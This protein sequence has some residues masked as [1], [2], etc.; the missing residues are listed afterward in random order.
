M[1]L[2]LLPVWV[3]QRRT[4]LRIACCFVFII[5]EHISILYVIVIY[6]NG[7]KKKRSFKIKWVY[8]HFLWWIRRFTIYKFVIEFRLYRTQRYIKSLTKVDFFPHICVK[9][10]KTICILKWVLFSTFYCFYLLEHLHTTN[11]KNRN[12]N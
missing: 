7:K 8:R 9:F 2:C 12:D 3:W 1:M 11:S 5:F 4:I 6:W 10:W